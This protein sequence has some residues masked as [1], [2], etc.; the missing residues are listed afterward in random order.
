[1]VEDGEPRLG[2]TRVDRRE[3]RGGMG[4]LVRQEGLDLLDTSERR[5]SAGNFARHPGNERRVLR[6]PRRPDLAED[7]EQE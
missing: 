7:V 5:A 6:Q 2:N 4:R 3:R 1:M